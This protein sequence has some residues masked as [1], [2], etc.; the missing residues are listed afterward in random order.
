MP[1]TRKSRDLTVMTAIPEL[2]EVGVNAA[3]QQHENYDRARISCN[4]PLSSLSETVK[5]KG[6]EDLSD[7]KQ[8]QEPHRPETIPWTGGYI[9]NGILKEGY[10][11]FEPG[12]VDSDPTSSEEGRNGGQKRRDRVHRASRRE[13]HKIAKM[14]ADNSL[15][16]LPPDIKIRDFAPPVQPPVRASRHGENQV[17]VSEEESASGT[18]AVRKSSSMQNTSDDEPSSATTLYCRFLHY[19][20]RMKMMAWI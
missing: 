1:R 4:P 11:P 7:G 10:S 18:V 9:Q 12:A 16:R 8:G 15:V 14:S 6:R 17:Q 13:F 3:L 5:G 19:V 2:A 20:V